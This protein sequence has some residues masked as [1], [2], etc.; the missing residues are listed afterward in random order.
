[1]DTPQNLDAFNKNSKLA[2]NPHSQTVIGYIIKVTG[3]K[4]NDGEFCNDLQSQLCTPPP[5]YEKSPI[6]SSVILLHHTALN[7]GNLSE[8]WV[9]CLCNEPMAVQSARHDSRLK[10]LPIT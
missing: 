7:S 3:S 8:R 1:L 2:Q 6:F 10:F 4:I 5:R 9:V